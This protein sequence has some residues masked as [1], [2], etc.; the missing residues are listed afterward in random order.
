M[1]QDFDQVICYRLVPSLLNAIRKASYDIVGADPFSQEATQ[2]AILDSLVD[3]LTGGTSTS[4][5][6]HI[7]QLNQQSA[8][9]F[10]QLKSVRRYKDM[11][12]KETQTKKARPAG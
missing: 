9:H 10:L 1:K 7:S 5:T 11:I 8:A 6:I 2:Q 12:M 4:K 3:F